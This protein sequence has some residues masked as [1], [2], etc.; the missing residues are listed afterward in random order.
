MTF[1]TLLHTTRDLEGNIYY[2]AQ[3]R[4]EKKELGLLR[5]D[6]ALYEKYLA[7]V[8]SSIH[9]YILD[10][11]IKKNIYKCAVKTI[12]THEKKLRNLT[13]NVTLSFTDT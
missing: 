13:K 5:K 2:A 8:L 7:K 4:K 11:P 3:L 9:K 1:Y 10:N 12:K 6:A